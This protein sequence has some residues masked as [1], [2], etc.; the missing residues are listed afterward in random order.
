MIKKR[1]GGLQLDELERALASRE[2]GSDLRGVKALLWKQAQLESEMGVYRERIGE[3]AANGEAL[4]AAG[5]FDAPAIRTQLQDFTKRFDALRKPCE[6]RRGELEE[7]RRLQQFLFDVECELQ[8]VAEK[9][10]QA[11]S[12]HTGTSLTDTT[13]LHKKHEV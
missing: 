11:A 3:I 6:R 8:W 10:P 4:A 1:T 2:L 12:T 13:R 9:R 7:S 5:H